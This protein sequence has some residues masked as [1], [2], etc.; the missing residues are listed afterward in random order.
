[1]A[2]NFNSYRFGLAEAILL[3]DTFLNCK[4][5]CIYNYIVNNSHI[6]NDK[7]F[8]TNFNIISNGRCL[9]YLLNQPTFWFR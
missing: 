9:V 6:A 2:D 4:N 1:M 3:E 8:K 7:T 5:F